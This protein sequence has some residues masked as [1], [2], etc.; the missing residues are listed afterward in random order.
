MSEAQLRSEL[1]E[2]FKNRAIIYHL[3]FDEMRRE[4]GA[5]KAEAVMGR[6][7]R[8]RGEQKGREKYGRFAPGD[9]SGVKRTFLSGSADGGRLFQPEVTH[10]DAAALDILQRK[11]PLQEAWQEMGLP[12]DEIATLCRIASQID[13]GTFGAAG[14]DFSLDS[15]QPDREGCCYLHIRPGKVK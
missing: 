10:E 5:E 6:A 2:S 7:L 15:W 8:R 11:C 14:F 1:V 13:F 3:I 4:F 9:L 12:D